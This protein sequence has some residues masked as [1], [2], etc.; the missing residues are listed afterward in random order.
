MVGLR[1]QPPAG[2]AEGA[3]VSGDLP[4]C[5]LIAAFESVVE[6]EEV[7]AGANIRVTVSAARAGG[8][9][10]FVVEGSVV[11]PIFEDDV[12]FRRHIETWA[13]AAPLLDGKPSGECLRLAMATVEG[14]TR[15]L[16]EVWS[17]QIA[18]RY[19]EDA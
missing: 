12:E 17:K 2:A 9:G 3:V 19:K 8:V 13:E 1:G 15:S 6:H 10:V 5:V 16:E 18:K 11:L 7:G 14:I 4:E